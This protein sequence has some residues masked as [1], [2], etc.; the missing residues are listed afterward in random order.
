M[1]TI[2]AN[3]TTY[4]TYTNPLTGLTTYSTSIN[5]INSTTTFFGGTA[6]TRNI[7]NTS[8]CGGGSPMCSG[9]KLFFPCTKNFGRGSEACFDFYIINPSTGEFVD[10]DTVEDME[11]SINNR[12][13]C[14]VGNVIYPCLLDD[15][16]ENEETVCAEPLQQKTGTLVFSDD[17][18]D[19]SKQF[20]HE[21]WFDD[22]EPCFEEFEKEF[23]SEDYEDYYNVFVE[24]D[25]ES[26]NVF[27]RIGNGE[28]SGYLTLKPLELTSKFSVSFDV[29]CN[30]SDV[31]LK[32]SANGKSM[33]TILNKTTESDS[34]EDNV[35]SAQNVTFEFDGMTESTRIEISSFSKTG[36]CEI[37]I[38]N[39]MV[40]SEEKITD[41]GKMNFCIPAKMTSKFVSGQLSITGNITING[42]I[43]S[44]PCAIFANVL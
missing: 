10:L 30:S 33:K 32:V 3:G 8:S 13:N 6:Y 11:L 38:D 18:E 24:Y 36:N 34:D 31:M 19:L 40:T 41:Q 39:L 43:F 1:A 25:K 22:E 27:L 42:S 37:F 28:H 4:T 17:F 26:D 12:F 2:Y 7:F 23:K 44:L 14:N 35:L 15:S 9:Y 5:G 20:K 16:E 29:M 21:E